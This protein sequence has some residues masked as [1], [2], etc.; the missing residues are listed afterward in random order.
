MAGGLGFKKHKDINSA[1]IAKL[2]WMIVSNRDRLCMRVLRTKYKI[3]HDWLRS[4]PPRTTSPIWRAIERAKSIIL[5][6]ACYLIGDGSSV[7][8]WRDPWLP[9]IQDFTPKP[10]DVNINQPPLK[11][12]RLIDSDL[13][14]WKALLVIQLFDPALAQAIL[15]IP[16]PLCLTPNK[17]I[18]VLDSKGAFTVKST[19]QATCH[20]PVAPSA[21]TSN[22]KQ[23]WN[24]KAPEKTKMFLWRMCVNVLPTRENIKM[25]MSLNDDSCLLCSEFPEDLIHLF[26]KCHIAKALWFTAVWGFRSEDFAATSSY[27]ITNLILNPP[28]LP[29]QASDQRIVSLT[30]TF[31][32]EEIWHLRNSNLHSK[33]YFSLTDSMLL[34]HRK[35]RE[36]T[37]VCLKPSSF[38]LRQPHPI[39][40]HLLLAGFR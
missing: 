23:H 1:L 32:L 21:P 38:R 39:G 20:L 11:V 22:W 10:R 40:S 36:F 15:S 12:S 34:I 25:R 19:Y 3:K 27:D 13:H 8:T 5:K 26:L 29:N 14:C 16:I 6:G 30:I 35:V 28:L 31:I 24:M 18:W 7:D 33:G 37:E 9:W 17:L 2:A 4:N